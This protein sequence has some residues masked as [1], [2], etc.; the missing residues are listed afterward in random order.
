MFLPPP[1]K[2]PGKATP[3][4]NSDGD[5]IPELFRLKF[6]EIILGL[7][8]GL[9]SELRPVS[10]LE[11]GEKLS[12]CSAN[13]QWL[14]DWTSLTGWIPAAYEAVAQNALDRSLG[15]HRRLSVR[16]NRERQRERRI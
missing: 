9:L 1:L 10:E 16:A 15:P 12:F 2:F 6:V 14:L 8:R 5:I 3:T 11:R 7:S 4:S 13:G